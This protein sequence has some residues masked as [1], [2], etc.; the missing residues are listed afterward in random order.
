M[1]LGTSTVF[2][3]VHCF[4]TLLRQIYTNVDKVAHVE[5][6][7][8]RLLLF[9]FHLILWLLI[10]LIIYL[11][12]WHNFATIYEFLGAVSTGLA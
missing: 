2:Y 5:L 12:R 11:L 7:M 4:A 3:F 10:Y 8:R 6:F 9:F 1:N